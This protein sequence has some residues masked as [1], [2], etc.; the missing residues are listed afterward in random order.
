MDT[1]LVSLAKQHFAVPRFP[2]ARSEVLRVEENE[3]GAC[4][5]GWGRINS[6]QQERKVGLR[7]LTLLAR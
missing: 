2:Y 7:R 4:F 6:R 1:L 3:Q 5:L